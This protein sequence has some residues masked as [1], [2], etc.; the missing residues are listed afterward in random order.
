GVVR[1][2]AGQLGTPGEKGVAPFHAGLLTLTAD[3]KLRAVGVLPDT[4]AARIIEATAPPEFR[5]AVEALQKKAE[6]IGDDVKSVEVSLNTEPPGF[7]PKFAGLRPT[8]VRYDP[9]TKT[10]T[11]FA[12]L[13]EKETK[14]LLVAAGD[15]DF[16][17][18]V[19]EL[20]GESNRFRVS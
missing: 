17:A 16:R 20:Y 11:A 9:A 14:G 8:V 1:N 2:D 10:L 7:D 18:T 5:K 4:E 13:A 12:P 6:A 15:P 3:G 19:N